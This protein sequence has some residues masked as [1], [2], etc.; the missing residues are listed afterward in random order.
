[1]TFANI[2]GHVNVLEVVHY[3]HNPYE[4]FDKNDEGGT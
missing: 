3:G 4:H 2:L 1:M